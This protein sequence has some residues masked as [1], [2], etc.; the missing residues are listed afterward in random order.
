MQFLFFY[1]IFRIIC[2]PNYVSSFLKKIRYFEPP[3]FLENI[4]ELELKFCSL[5]G[6]VADLYFL[7]KALHSDSI[8]YQFFKLSNN[9]K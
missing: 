7:Y 3:Y 2:K 6:Q 8:N 4:I 5:T 1:V 9:M